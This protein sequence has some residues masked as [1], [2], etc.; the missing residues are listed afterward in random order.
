MRLKLISILMIAIAA[1]SYP[2]NGQSTSEFKAK[3]VDNI[4]KA[5]VANARIILATKTKDKPECLININLTAVSKENGEISIPDVPAGE[6]VILYNVTGTLDTLMANKV[7]G[8]DPVNRGDIRS[9]FAYT[10]HITNSLGGQLYVASGSEF[11]IV[12]GN[13]VIEGYFYADKYDL[14]M[15]SKDGRLLQVE[16]PLKMSEELSI[17]INTSI[18]KTK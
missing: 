2:A 4:T 5:P 3:L 18:G 7:I 17:E 13:M 1:I 11:R 6:Y 8:Y 12:D 10:Q 15:I 9:G 16:I 14:G